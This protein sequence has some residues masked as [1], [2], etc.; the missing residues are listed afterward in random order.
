VNHGPELKICGITNAEDARLVGSIGADYCGM[1]VE[2]GFSERSLS[3]PRAREIAEE[4]LETRVV[5]LLCD[6]EVP[7]VQEVAR[8]IRPYAIQFLCGESPDFIMDMKRRLSCRVWK[9]VHL[10]VG[11]GQ[12]C[13]EDYI[14]AGVDA[15]L[16]DT[17]DTTEGFVRMGGTGKVADWAVATSVVESVSV[18]VFLGGGI[19]PENVADGLLQVRPHGIDLCSGVEKRKGKK[20]AAKLRRLVAGFRAAVARMEE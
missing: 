20:D 1:L 3:L 10:P 16:I 19:D 17:V 14:T 18:P 8:S 5:I 12:A 15:L 2:V 4:C 13:P 6:P 7:L 11:H 9:S